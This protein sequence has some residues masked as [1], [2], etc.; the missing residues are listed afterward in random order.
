M[1]VEPEILAH[2]QELAYGG[3]TRAKTPKDVAEQ[4]IKDG[5]ARHAV[6]GL[7][8]TDAAH[9][10]LVAKGIKPPRWK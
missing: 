5:Y 4:L 2:I 1:T 10:L 6:G 9:R 7:M 3:L 8:A